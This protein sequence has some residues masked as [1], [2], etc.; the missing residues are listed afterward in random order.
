MLVDFFCAFMLF[1]GVLYFLRIL[2]IEFLED[3]LIC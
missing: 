2:F 3:H 1:V